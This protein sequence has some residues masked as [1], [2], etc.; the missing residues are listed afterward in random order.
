MTSVAVPTSAPA[1]GSQRFRPLRVKAVVR[2]SADAISV[3]IEVP[4]ELASTYIY[5]AGQY[6]T[7]SW[8][9]K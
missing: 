9:E 2:E 1:R 4:P 7:L 8:R 6:V 3:V 5:E